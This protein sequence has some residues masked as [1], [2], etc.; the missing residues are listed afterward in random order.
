MDRPLSYNSKKVGGKI[1]AQKRTATNHIKAQFKRRTFRWM[2][3]RSGLSKLEIDDLFRRAR[4]GE[5]MP[6][7]EAIATAE[8]KGIRRITRYTLRHFMATR[9]R[10]L[11]KIRGPGMKATT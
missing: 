2:L 5:S 4:K 6:L 11:E 10:G 7:K 3:V 9:I 8:E 1:P